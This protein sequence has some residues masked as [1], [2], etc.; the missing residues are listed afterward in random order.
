MEAVATTKEVVSAFGSYW[1]FTLVVI[2]G[3]YG[4][5]VWLDKREHLS[6]DARESVA[7]WL[8][9]AHESSWATQFCRLF[10]SVFSDRHLSWRCF[11]RSALASVILLLNMTIVTI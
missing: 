11:Y 2:G 5:L 10:D 1:A 6:A 4:A 8:L 3:F 9:G 7:L